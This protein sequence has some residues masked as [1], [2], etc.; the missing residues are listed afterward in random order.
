MEKYIENT[1][2]YYDENFKV[3]SEEWSNNFTSNFNFENPN[4]FISYLRDGAYVLDLGCGHGR[5]TMYF[6]EKGYKVKAIDGSLEM[7]RL[8]SKNTGIN[9]EQ[10]NFLDMDY[11]DLFDGVFASASLLHLNNKDLIIVLKK[12]SKALKTGGILMASFKYGD[13]ERLKE[14]RYFN[15]MTE[16]KFSKLLESVSEFVLERVLTND[17]FKNHK[18]FIT[19]VLKKVRLY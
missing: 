11:N 19:F 1:L 6:I 17:G 9:V 3:Y 4:I 5:D 13:N 8:A 2:R 7:C 18:S 16:V 12:I 14:G 15:D 10:I